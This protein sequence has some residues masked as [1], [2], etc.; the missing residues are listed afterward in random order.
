MIN[1]LN[2]K[3]EQVIKEKEDFLIKTEKEFEN[4]SVNL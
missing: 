3:V 4:K 1:E 2:N